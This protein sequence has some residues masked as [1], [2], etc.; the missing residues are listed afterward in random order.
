MSIDQAMWYSAKPE[1]GLLAIEV[2]NGIKS[3]FSGEP[4][5]SA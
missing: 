2:K 5:E 3:A 1:F 4:L